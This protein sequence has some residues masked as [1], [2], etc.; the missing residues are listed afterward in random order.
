MRYVITAPPYTHK[1]AGIKVLYELQK[2]LIRYG[3]DAMI[4]N[5]KSPYR[6]E[7]DDIVVYP[8]I[9]SGNPLRAKRV[10]RYILNHPGLLGGDKEYDRNEIL[11]AYDS[12]LAQYSN[13][14]I[15]TTPCIEDFFSDMGYERTLNCFYVGKGT[16]THHPAT[17]A[18]IEITSRWPARRRELA[19]LLNRT[20]TFYTYDQRTA[21]IT[22]ATRCGCTVRIVVGEEL[23][24]NPLEKFDLEG[25]KLQMEQFIRMTWYPEIDL[26]RDASRSLD[27]ALSALAMARHLDTGAQR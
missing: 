1:S 5:F 12:A 6:A 4:L 10:V 20:R 26:R 27:T 25:F 23:S 9:V 7:D 16:N 14:V 18:C 15:L 19:E 8:E 2:W 13:G 22:E 21:L 3:K 24:E 11:I 17:R